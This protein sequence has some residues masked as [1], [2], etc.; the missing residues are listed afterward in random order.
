[1][2]KLIKNKLIKKLTITTLLFG[3]FAGSTVLNSEQAHASTKSYTYKV[4]KGDTLSKI[5]KKK[6]TTVTNLKKLNKLKSNL[7][8]V[9]QKLKYK[10][11]I[12]KTTKKRFLRI[13]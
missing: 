8:F 2:K 13:M 9:G 7:I 6:K 4:V 3:G 12:K 11:T 1:M 5:A 10:G